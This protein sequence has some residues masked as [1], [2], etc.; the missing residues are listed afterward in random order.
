MSRGDLK[1]GIDMRGIDPTSFGA[2]RP[3]AVTVGQVLKQHAVEPFEFSDWTTVTTPLFRAI[4]VKISVRGH[5]ND[6][7]HD[8]ENRF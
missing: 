6:G 5:C 4:V 1:A 3:L 8:H 2:A 7:Q